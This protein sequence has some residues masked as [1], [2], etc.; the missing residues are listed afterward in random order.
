ML[1]VTVV[2]HFDGDRARLW[3]GLADL[4]AHREWMTDVRSLRFL[5]PQRT[6]VG[7]RYVIEVAVGPGRVRDHIEVTAWDRPGRWRSRTASPG[8]AVRAASCWRMPGTG[9]GWSGGRGSR[10]RG[11]RAVRS[12]RGSAP[13][14]PAAC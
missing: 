5:T 2:E 8:C 11:G 14:R 6:G 9:R 13:H 1:E 4:E 12:R 3:D 7:T 10:S